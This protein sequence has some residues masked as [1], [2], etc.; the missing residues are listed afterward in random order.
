MN[1]DAKTTSFATLATEP[2]PLDY[3]NWVHLNTGDRVIV[4]RYGFE[5]E[6]GTL[7]IVS[8]DATY[9]WVWLDGQSR[10]LIFHGDGAVIHKS[11]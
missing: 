5:P 11:F 6:H 10:V 1:G 9:F 3:H 4:S 8:E 7:E 2:R